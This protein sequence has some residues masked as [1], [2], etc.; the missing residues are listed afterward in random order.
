MSERTDRP[1]SREELVFDVDM[2][3]RRN[4][5]LWPKRRRPGDHDRFRMMA[6]AIVD[7]LEMSGTRFI[8]QTAVSELKPPDPPDC[9]PDRDREGEEPA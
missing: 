4:Q 2:A 1:M 5:R 6:C 9:G 8:G 3:L 7:H